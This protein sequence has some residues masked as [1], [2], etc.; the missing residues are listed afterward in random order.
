MVTPGAPAPVARLYP[1]QTMPVA[2]TDVIPRMPEPPSYDLSVVTVCRNDISGLIATVES[3]LR[4][5]ARGTLRIEHVIVDGD[6]DDGTKEWLTQMRQQGKIEHFVSEPDRG[7]Y[8]A[9]N[10]GINMAHGAALAFLNAG[11]TYTDADLAPCIRPIADG[12]T[13]HTAAAAALSD[14]QTGQSHPLSIF[15]PTAVLI[16]TPCCHQA[17][18]AAT[19][20]YRS[21]G[22]YAAQQYRCCADGDIMSRIILKVGEPVLIPHTIVNFATGGLSDACGIWFIDE[23]IHLQYTYHAAAMVRANLNRDYARA[24]AAALL[25]HYVNLPLWLQKHPEAPK[26]EL[27]QQLITL[28]RDT[29][30]LPNGKLCMYLLRVLADKRLPQIRAG[31]KCKPRQPWGLHV[32]IKYCSERL[33]H[34]SRLCLYSALLIIYRELRYLLQ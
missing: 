25:Q 28:C 34:P 8:D 24:L 14:T 17:Y 32:L 29:A 4:Q 21:L 23:F 22:G 27:L 7:I 2:Y 18:F 13:Q 12:S 10:K 15:K 31:A 30:T 33:T 26:E 16:A 19:E 1:F 11:D 9:M 20:L 3:V 6:S 5:K